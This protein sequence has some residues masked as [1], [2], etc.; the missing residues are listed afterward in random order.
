MTSIRL[1]ILTTAVVVLGTGAPPAAAQSLDFQTYKTQVEPVFTKKRPGHA[2]CVVCHSES[3]NAFRLQK[4]PENGAS[5][6]EE[7]SRQNFENVRNLVKP[8]DPASSKLLMHP[9]APD[10]GGDEG[11][12]GG[13]QFES[14]NDPAWQ[15]MAAWVR[16]AK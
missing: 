15:A 3:N 8:G 7:Q 4:R 6:T 9:L 1:A 11:H 10:A 13:W 16:S 12:G 2:R 14:K 5:W